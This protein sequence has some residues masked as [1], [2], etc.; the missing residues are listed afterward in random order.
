[1]RSE[2][3]LA[4]RWT[5]EL[6]AAFSTLERVRV[7]EL[8]REIAQGR[9]LKTKV[10]M[11]VPGHERATEKEYVHEQ[12]VLNAPIALRPTDGSIVWHPFNAA[13]GRSD[14][15][16]RRELSDRLLVSLGAL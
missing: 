5:G 9:K 12:T 2:P 10:V 15:V 1:V 16:Y 11:A 13:V 8:K 4:A 6:D 3:T 14:E 7:S